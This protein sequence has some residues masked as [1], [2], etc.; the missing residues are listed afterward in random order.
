MRFTRKGLA[1]V[2]VVGVLTVSG[3]AA[4]EAPESDSVNPVGVSRTLDSSPLRILL[5]NDD[6]WGAGGIVATYEALTEA[7]HDVTVVA[8]DENFSG[9]SSAVDFRGELTVVQQEEN[10]YTVSGTPA[11]SV[12]YGV[13]QVL[14]GQ[15]PDLVVSGTNVGSNT[16]FDQNFSGTIGAAVVASGMFD[17]PAIAISTETKRG[18]EANAAYRQT[19]DLLVEL[20]AT[21]DVDIRSGEVLN[22]NYP[23]LSDGADVPEVRVAPAAEESAAAFAFEEVGP[24]RWAIV[25][26]RSDDVPAPGSDAALLAEGF[27][28]VDMLTVSRTVNSERHAELEDLASALNAGN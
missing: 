10:V 22:I 7:G 12:I 14:G 28:T 13:E 21:G 18:E 20:L 9:V 2:A 24:E 6:G 3:C 11:T 1:A 8:P 15:V 5:T 19:A 27:V 4:G 26:A 16:G 17:I 23:I 25:P